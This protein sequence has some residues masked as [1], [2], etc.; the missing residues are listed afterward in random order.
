MIPIIDSHLDLSWNA[1]SWNRD[2]TQSVAEIRAI[3]SAMTDSPA[4][5]RN[6]VSLP[7]LRRG[8]V[9]VCLATI[10]VRARPGLHPSAGFKRTDLDFRDQIV[11]CATGRGQLEYYRLLEERGQIRFIRSAAELPSH[12]EKW[13]SNR[14]KCPIGI[15]LSMEGADP[16][17]EPAQVAWWFEAG[18][19]TVGL[20]HYGKGPY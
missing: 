17:V 20:V 5:G 4:R 6:T 1:L 13:T 16:I 10:L 19:R 14:E 12:W 18:L 15:I 8:N 2:L 11:A 3:E 9:A 7:D